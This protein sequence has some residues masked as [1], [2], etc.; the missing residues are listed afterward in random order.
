[1]YNIAV[2][3][4]FIVFTLSQS[5]HHQPAASENTNVVLHN[6]TFLAGCAAYVTSK[7]SLCAQS[8]R[9]GKTL[10]IYILL[11]THVNSLKVTVFT[12]LYKEPEQLLDEAGAQKVAFML[13]VGPLANPDWDQ[14]LLE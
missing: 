3:F 5:T 1:M 4:S 12:Q 9:G 6:V 11:T 8:K 7:L 2:T 13:S 14:P 10:K